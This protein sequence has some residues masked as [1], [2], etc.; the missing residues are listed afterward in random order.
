MNNFFGFVNTITKIHNITSV[1][2]GM[3]KR[4]INTRRWAVEKP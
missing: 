4:R 1:C 3:N 2:K